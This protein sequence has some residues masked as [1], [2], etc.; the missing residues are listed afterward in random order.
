LVTAH[1]YQIFADSTIFTHSA[2]HFL[3]KKWTAFLRLAFVHPGLPLPPL[4]SMMISQSNQYHHHRLLMMMILLTIL[5][6]L[7]MIVMMIA[8]IP[9]LATSS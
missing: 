3:K 7:M 9:M 2:S 6:H 8:L 5:D 1:R 4:V